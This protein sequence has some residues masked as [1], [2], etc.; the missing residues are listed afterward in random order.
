SDPVQVGERWSIVKLT[1]MRPAEHRSFEQAAP[2]IR[3]R[4]WRERRQGSLEELVTRLR[5][6]AGVEPS[7][8][9]LRQIRLDAPAREDEARG[10]QA[11]PPT[12]T[13]PAETAP[14]DPASAAN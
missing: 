12:E 13:A 2:S 7:Y 11:T 9:L 1:G 3:L 10:E 6:E 5:R 8:E 4:L 14:A